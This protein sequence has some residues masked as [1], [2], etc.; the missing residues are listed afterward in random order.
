MP[1][2]GPMELLIILLILLLLFGANRLAGLGAAAGK[3]VKEF[4][5]AISDVEEDV[6]D[7]K[8]TKPSA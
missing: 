1:N 5:K 3:T 8:P 6:K 7:T 4:R 2:V